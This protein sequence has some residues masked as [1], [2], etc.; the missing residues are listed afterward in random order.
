[1]RTLRI[2]AAGWILGA[3]VIVLLT[4]PEMRARTVRP[5]TAPTAT[6][7]MTTTK[8]AQ[9]VVESPMNIQDPARLPVNL[10]GTIPEHSDD[11]LIPVAG[12][13]V[14]DL[15]DNYLQARGGGTRLHGAIDIMAPR[16]TPVLAAV[17]GTIRKLFTSH[18]GGLTIYQYDVAEQRIYYY[19]HLDSYAPTAQEGLFI[20]RGTVI[21]YVGTT[22]NAAPDAPHLHFAIEL[23]PPT[24]E[25]WKGTP[26]N[27]YP[28]LTGVTT[29][30]S[31][32]P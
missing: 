25:W 21:G 31:T 26:I 32:L 3:A 30:S 19:A 7:T 1:M 2:L 14:S 28:I 23:L 29:P 22:G 6:P 27:P 4:V 15:H 18:G 24:K 8:A 17:D 9:I 20:H 5:K 16:G 13:T 11:V 12:I 10:S